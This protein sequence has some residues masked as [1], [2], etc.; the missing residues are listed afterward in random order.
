[1]FY[2]LPCHVSS[3]SPAQTEEERCGGHHSRG[4]GHEALLPRVT[5]VCPQR[6]GRGGPMSNILQALE[7]ISW[8]PPLPASTRQHPCSSFILKLTEEAALGKPF[9]Y[10]LASHPYS[11]EEGMARA[12]GPGSLF[13]VVITEPCLVLARLLQ[14]LPAN[15][16]G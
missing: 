15:Y 7:D 3:H 16:C 6:W 10:A 8:S 13:P 9:P 2:R 14:H 4:E 11:L 5:R 1:M 12:T